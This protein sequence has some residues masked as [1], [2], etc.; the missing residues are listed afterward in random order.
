M[1]NEIEKAID[2][3]K[4]SLINSREIGGW[5]FHGVRHEPLITTISAL[6]K[7]IPKSVSF[8]I[9]NPKNIYCHCCG[10]NVRDLKDLYDNNFCIKCGQALLWE[11]HKK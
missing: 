10:K 6:E 5:K 1:E 4:T 8:D 2:A 7:Q 9:N 11:G 3:I